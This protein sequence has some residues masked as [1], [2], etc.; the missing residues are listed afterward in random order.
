MNILDKIVEYKRAEV[1][2]S[3]KERPLASL[4]SSPHYR[5]RTNDIMLGGESGKPG[6]IAE[7]KRKQFLIETAPQLYRL[8][9]EELEAIAQE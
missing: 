3:K 5:R 9:V 2:E 7:F 4:N 8:N 1:L 6:I